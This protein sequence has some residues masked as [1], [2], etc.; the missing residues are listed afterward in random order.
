MNIGGS[1]NIG[2]KIYIS[3]GHISAEVKNFLIDHPTIEGKKL[4]HGCWKVPKMAFIVLEQ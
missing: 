1:L 3:D 4:R 2:N